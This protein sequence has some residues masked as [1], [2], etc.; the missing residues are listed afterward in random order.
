[1]GDTAVTFRNTFAVASVP[2]GTYDVTAAVSI[3]GETLQLLPISYTTSVD[4]NEINASE[5]D[6]EYYNLQGVK[7]NN[8]ENGI[9][10]D[11]NGNK[12]VIK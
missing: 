2:A 12:V 3:Y 4:V 1:M 8:P 6:N 10:V 7:I 9:F 5:A 11:K